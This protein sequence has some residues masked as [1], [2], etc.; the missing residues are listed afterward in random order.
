MSKKSLNISS[1][2]GASILPNL[3]WIQDHL[4]YSGKLLKIVLVKIPPHLNS[5]LL[6]AVIGLDGKGNGS[7]ILGI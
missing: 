1:T 7:F 4:K 3:A 2:A 6:R 5:A